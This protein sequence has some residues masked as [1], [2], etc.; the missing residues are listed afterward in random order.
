MFNG[1]ITSARITRKNELEKYIKHN[2]IIFNDNLDGL[3]NMLIDGN[4]E[5]N[6]IGLSMLD[7]Y[8]VYHYLRW[9]YF[10]KTYFI[11]ELGVNCLLECNAYLIS[12][13]SIGKEKEYIEFEQNRYLYNDD[14]YM[15]LYTAPFELLF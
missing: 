13:I 2:K 3:W 9:N 12:K 6:N 5:D 11:T 10:E 4:P 1:Q 7:S 14:S 15:H 8:G